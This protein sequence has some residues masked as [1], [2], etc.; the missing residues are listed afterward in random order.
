MNLFN[1]F[2]TRDNMRGLSSILSLFRNELNK[3]NNTGARTLY[4]I[5]HM[6]LNLN[7]TAL[8]LACISYIYRVIVPL[9]SFSVLC[10][11]YNDPS[12]K[13]N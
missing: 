5:Y 6:T 12:T 1:E 2:G 9:F 8:P 3:F 13:Q 7:Y 11:P 4:Y 10:F